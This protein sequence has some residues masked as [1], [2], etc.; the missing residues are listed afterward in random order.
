MST[1]DDLLL[2]PL[3]KTQIQDFI[4]KTSH[5]LVITGA[6]GSGK[7]TV[8]QKIAVAILKLKS[9]AKLKKYPYFA[10]IKKPE[11][12]QDIPIDSV[13]Q[14]SKMLKLKI[15]GTIDIKRVIVIEDAQDL[16]EEAGNAMLK[17]LEEPTADC[18]FILTTDTANNLLPTIISRAQQ[19]QVQP[20]T[21][22]DA[23]VFFA[24]QYSIEQIES[25]WNLSQGSAGLMLALLK[26]DNKSPL[27]IAVDAAKDYLQ[28]NKYQRL[29]MADG[30][31]KDK[32][33]L[34]IFLA[35]LLKVLAALHHSV[36]KRGDRAQQGKILAS[37]KLVYQMQDAL[38]A[39]VSPKLVT[40]ELSL[41]LL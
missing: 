30:L 9:D 37:R 14:L 21:L 38:D 23:R 7:Y 6:V 27:K 28:K 10:H 32:K 11:M 1:L 22:N 12:K 4:K 26:D 3:T 35:A 19:L 25:A 15:P 33:Q 40:L 20:V 5:A 24:G 36:V 8:A 17:M 2:H 13:R 34:S 16:N 41:N 29:L 31:S 18:V 39:N